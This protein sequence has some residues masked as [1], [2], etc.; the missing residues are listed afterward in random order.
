MQ[1]RTLH[2]EKGRGFGHF[3]LRVCAPAIHAT[4]SGYAFDGWPLKK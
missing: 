4:K 2:V 3:R 1:A